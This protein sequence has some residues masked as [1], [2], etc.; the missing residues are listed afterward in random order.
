MSICM[1]KK[2]LF[3]PKIALSHDFNKI[4]VNPDFNSDCECGPFN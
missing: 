4:S 3:L 2:N 1:K